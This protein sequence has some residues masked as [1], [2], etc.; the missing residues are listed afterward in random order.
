LVEENMKGIYLV[1]DT[2]ACKG[3]SLESVVS[4]AV[5]AGVAFVQLREKHADTRVFLE[6]ALRLKA[7]LKPAGVPLIINDRVDIALAAKAD[8]VHLGQSDMPYTYARNLLGEKAIIGLSV[9]KWEHVKEAQT[10]NV[11]YLGVSPVFLTPTKTDT[12]TPWGIEGL[13]KIKKFSCHKLVA[14]GG[15][16]RSNACEVISAGADCLAVVSAICSADDPFEATWELC[17]TIN[18]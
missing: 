9:E 13:K 1:T 2:G 6:K 10:L 5:R 14:I 17:R 11:D 8:G 16:N 18:N 3:K 7:I 4:D 15:I 12:K